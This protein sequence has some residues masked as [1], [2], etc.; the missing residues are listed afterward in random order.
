MQG[1]RALAG[2]LAEQGWVL[3]TRPGCPF[4]ENQMQVLGGSYPRSAVCSG[5]SVCSAGVPTWSN[6]ASG[7]RRVGFQDAAALEKMAQRIA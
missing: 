3:Y 7:E 5:E 2:R 4:C 6:A 1:S